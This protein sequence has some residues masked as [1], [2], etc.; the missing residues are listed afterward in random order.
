MLRFYLPPGK[1]NVKPS[2]HRQ[3]ATRF[4]E[5]FPRPGGQASA[6]TGHRCTEAVA[7]HSRRIVKCAVQGENR[8]ASRRDLSRTS[9]FSSVPKASGSWE[10]AERISNSKGSMGNI[11]RKNP[12]KVPCETEYNLIR[13]V[14]EKMDGLSF[15]QRSLPLRT[16]LKIC[17]ASQLKCYIAAGASL[18]DGYAHLYYSSQISS[19]QAR[20]QGMLLPRP[21]DFGSR[22]E[23]VTEHG[24]IT[25]PD[26]NPVFD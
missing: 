8:S 17:S 1:K 18:I 5:K 25:E 9:S 4:F 16:W 10:T 15:C 20:E 6:G 12:A 14:I 23:D 7:G 11:Q 22:W 24:K 26:L 21:D 13:P 19:A 2:R 3:K